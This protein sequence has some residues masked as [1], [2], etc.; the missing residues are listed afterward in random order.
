MKHDLFMVRHRKLFIVIPVILTI[1]MLFPLLKSR[2]NTDLMTYLPDDVPARIDLNELESTFGK[3]DP[4]V[5]LFES[6]DI[7]KASTLVRLDSLNQYYANNQYIKQVISVFQLKNV[8]NEEGSMIVEPVISSIPA[9]DK[10]RNNLRNEIKK[11]P[12]VYKVVVSDD[13]RYTIMLLNPADSV[14]DR[15]LNKIIKTSLLK[16]PGNEKVYIGGLPSLRNDIQ[17]IAIR[18]LAILM[19]LGLLI[20]LLTLYFSFRE[21]KGVLL[22][23]SVVVMSIGIAMGLM[24]LLGFDF[25]LLAILVPVMMIAIANNYGVHIMTR[26]Q[27][28]NFVH[29]GWGMKRIVNESVKKL[30]TPIILTALTTVVGV[31]GLVSHVLEPVKQIGIVCS[32]GILFALAASLFYIPAVMSGVKKG[33]KSSHFEVKPEGLIGHLLDRAGFVS[34]RKPW[35]VIF[36]FLIMLIVSGIGINWLKV[37]VNLEEMMPKNNPLRTS[38]QVMN[39]KFTGNKIVNVMFEGDMKSPEVLHSIDDFDN[40]IRKFPEVGNVTS[41]ATLMHTISK[42]MNLPGDSLYDKIPND[43]N[44]ISQYIEF[45]NMN[46][47][48]TDFENLVDFGYTKSV[49]AIQFNVK[50]YKSFKKT[51]KE[52]RRI[53]GENKYCKLVS[54]QSIVEKSLSEAVVKGQFLSL[55]FAMISIIVM[56]WIMFRSLSGGLMCAIPLFVSVIFNF[57]LMGWLGIELDIATSLLSSISIGIGVD[58][59]IHL[60][61]RINHELQHGKSW[62]EAISYTLRSTGRGISINA[63]SVMI[64]FSVLFISGLTILKAFGFLIIFSLLICLLC[65]LLLIPSLTMLGKPKFLMNHNKAQ[66]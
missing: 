1:L 2:I 53:A 48:T 50:D 36:T 21:K 57:G 66:E 44:M 38:A 14:S 30:Y 28:L 47:G 46:S 20:M 52:I 17:R 15:D 13:F 11:N 37:S 62:A 51:E 61:W 64:G 33:K 63:F 8:S 58:Y 59:T 7:I 34:T 3:Y 35:Y 22:P 4:A 27:E 16:Y 56:L 29:P 10:D 6:D 24:P 60:F 12:L 23:F 26:Y 55:A 25:S 42:G 18:D 5:L 19:P 9:N 40:Q 45:Y 65:A 43:G 49:S 32:V 39:E 31:L 41:F 54:G